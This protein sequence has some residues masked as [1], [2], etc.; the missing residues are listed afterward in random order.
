[1]ALPDL[2]SFRTDPTTRIQRGVLISTNQKDHPIFFVSIVHVAHLP[3]IPRIALV[4]SE[5]TRCSAPWVFSPW[6]AIRGL[7][8]PAASS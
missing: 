8:H 5:A 2:G 1:M 3:T 7:F 4:E 6:I